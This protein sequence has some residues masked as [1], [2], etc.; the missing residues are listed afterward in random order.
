MSLAAT[1][2]SS[3]LAFRSTFNSSTTAPAAG[4]CVTAGRWMTGA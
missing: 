1:P 2:A 4:V 3:A